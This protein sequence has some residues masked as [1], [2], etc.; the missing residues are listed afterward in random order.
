MTEKHGGNCHPR[1]LTVNMVRIHREP[2]ND[3]PVRQ[4]VQNEVR[5]VPPIRPLMR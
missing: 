5:V 2:R 3:R 1:F 4:H